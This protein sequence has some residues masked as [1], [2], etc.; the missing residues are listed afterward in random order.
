VIG[1][2]RARRWLDGT[3]RAK[4]RAAASLRGEAGNQLAR[5]LYKGRPIVGVKAH[6]LLS[7]FVEIFLDEVYAVRFS[8]ATPRIIDCGANYGLLGVYLA[9]QYPAMSYLAFE[10][11]PQACLAI[12]QN[13]AEWLASTR[14]EVRNAALAGE[15]GERQFCFRGDMAGRLQSDA[16]EQ[17]PP[18]RIDKVACET[19]G[20]HLDSPVDLLKID[21]E[22]AE[23]EVVSSVA[24]KLR[25]V[26]R[27]FIEY[28]SHRDVHPQNLHG[29]LRIVSDAGFRYIVHEVQSPEWRI[30][31]H[32]FVA[33]RFDEQLGFDSQL[34]VFCIRR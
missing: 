3:Y 20:S 34:N 6:A 25:N 28:H 29:L 4:R 22:G 7:G 5:I 2:N 18:G 11:D 8:S 26:D 15:A 12:R 13:L 10:P 31:A 32:P 1:L 24:G 17:T 30:N 21:I 33:H 23:F 19:L 16:S 9:E 14:W 27:L